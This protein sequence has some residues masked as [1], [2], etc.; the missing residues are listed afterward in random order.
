[1][2]IKDFPEAI[3]VSPQSILHTA[4]PN[5]KVDFFRE[6]ISTKIVQPEKVLTISDVIVMSKN[7]SDFKENLSL[8]KE[9]LESIEKFTIGQSENEHWFEYRKCLI[10]ASKAH[11]VVTKMTKVEKG[12]GGTVNI[13]SLNQKISG[14][15][16]VKPN[17]TAVKY[18]RDMEIEA[19][20]THSLN[21]SR[22]N[23]RTSN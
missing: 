15:V 13:W 20:K 5:P 3:K 6:L 11:E 1:M 10:T 18:G 23:I 12:D 21:L 16:F 17:I 7:M 4:V 14:R 8:S 9:N 19:V 22:G 2:S